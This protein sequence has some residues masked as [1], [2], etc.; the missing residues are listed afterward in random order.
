MWSG[1]FA[2]TVADEKRRQEGPQPG[3]VRMSSIL[4]WHNFD[5]DR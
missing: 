1:S 5:K 4:G 2:L 3:P